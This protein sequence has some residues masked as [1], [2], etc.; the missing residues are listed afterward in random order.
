[1][2]SV[3]DATQPVVERIR[4][5]KE[6]L[7]QLEDGIHRLH[8]LASKIE[9]NNLMIDIAEGAGSF[10][11]VPVSSYITSGNEKYIFGPSSRIRDTIVEFL[12]AENS[13]LADML[14]D[15]LNEVKELSELET[16]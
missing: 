3:R 2:L 10:E 5:L 14:H 9:H 15:V 7:G 8:E 12:K 4:D 11:V 6:S 13:L 16:S 1:M